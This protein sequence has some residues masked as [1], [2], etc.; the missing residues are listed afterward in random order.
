MKLICGAVYIIDFTNQQCMIE[1]ED[2]KEELA[3]PILQLSSENMTRY[4]I[5]LM[6]Y[7]LVSTSFVYSYPL[8][9]LFANSILW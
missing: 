4:G 8:H 2:G 1:R 3:P 5:F 6:D 9:S 7:G